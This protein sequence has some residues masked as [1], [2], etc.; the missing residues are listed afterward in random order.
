ML[1]WVGLGAVLALSL[2]AM[3]AGPA[4]PARRKSRHMAGPVHEEAEE[5]LDLLARDAPSAL[6]RYGTPEDVQYLR[7]TG[8]A[9]D[10]PGLGYR[11]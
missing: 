7:E 9:D 8:R 1:L 10:L 2:A 6:L 3:A 4:P 5:P 11:D